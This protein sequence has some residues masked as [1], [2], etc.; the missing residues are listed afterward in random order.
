M[1]NNKQQQSWAQLPITAPKFNPASYPSSLFSIGFESGKMFTYSAGPKIAQVGLEFFAGLT[2]DTDFERLDPKQ[3]AAVTTLLATEGLRP[4]NHVIVT[5]LEKNVPIGPMGSGATVKKVDS[6]CVLTENR[7]AQTPYMVY[8]EDYRRYNIALN[9]D[10]AIDDPS[11]TLRRNLRINH[12]ADQARRA[13]VTKAKKAMNPPT[14]ANP[15]SKRQLKKAAHKVRMAKQKADNE[16]LTEDKRIEKERVAK[17]L[18]EEKKKHEPTVIK[19]KAQAEMRAEELKA[20]SAARQ[21]ADQLRKADHNVQVE[22]DLDGWKLVTSKRP[23][24]KSVVT[25]SGTAATRSDGTSN[26]TTT[27][28][29]VFGT[30]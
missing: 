21:R 1:S 7:P 8:L 4:S 11:N 24:R 2:G 9:G 10:K 18:A 25:V 22:V 14:P 20:A 30:T 6:I 19:L 13:K 17:L 5:V 29:V 3:K 26:L 15:N 23:T 28:S 16:K 12:D 27:R